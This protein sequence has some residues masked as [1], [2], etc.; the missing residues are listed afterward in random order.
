[1]LHALILAVTLGGA[2]DEVAPG[3]PK[4]DLAA[5]HEAAGKAGKS[6]PPMSDWRSGARPTA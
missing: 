6:A 2:F 4:P 1:M 5:Y 3:S